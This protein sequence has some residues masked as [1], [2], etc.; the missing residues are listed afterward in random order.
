MFSAQ[1]IVKCLGR[2]LSA[3]PQLPSCFDFSDFLPPAVTN[4]QRHCSTPVNASFTQA[5]L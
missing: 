1:K 2:I 5:T 3:D 4:Q